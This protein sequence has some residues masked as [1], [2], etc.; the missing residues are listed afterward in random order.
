[1]FKKARNQFDQ[2][3]LNP[4]LYFRM[5][6]YGWQYNKII[7]HGL[8]LVINEPPERFLVICNARTGSNYLL[9]ALGSHPL[10]RQ[11][12]EPF[13][14]N[15]LNNKEGVKEKIL[16]LGL[17]PYLEFIMRRQGGEAVVG[18]KTLYGQLEDSYGEK[19]GVP[20][21]ADAREF[22][23]RSRDLK[24]IHLKR[25]D[26]LATIASLMLAIETKRFLIQDPQD[27][28]TERQVEI[29]INSCNWHFNQIHRREKLYDDTFS[30]HRKTEIYYEELV[31]RPAAVHSQILEFLGMPDR[32]LR[33]RLIKQNIRPLKDVIANYAE[34]KAYFADTPWARYFTD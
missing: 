13:G 5:L 22:L 3:N 20:D 16:E 14:P 4:F 7:S 33:S 2:N 28:E 9:T 27:R 1:M 29:P 21:I 24:V 25:H 11:F 34:L 23:K 15:S 10:I 31:A 6:I 32:P 8:R 30:F 26:K 18:F 17:V 12:W 19:Q